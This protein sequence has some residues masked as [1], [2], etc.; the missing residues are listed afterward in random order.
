MILPDGEQAWFLNGERL[1]Y[2]TSRKSDQWTWTDHQTRFIIW[3]L[4][5]ISE[6]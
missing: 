6:S 5:Q 4:M 3:I 1:M 2:R